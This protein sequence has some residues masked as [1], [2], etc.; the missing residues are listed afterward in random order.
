MPVTPRHTIM[1]SVGTSKCAHMAGEHSHAWME[2]NYI[3]TPF[4]A[5]YQQRPEVAPQKFV[6]VYISD[7]WWEK[8]YQDKSVGCNL[9]RLL[10]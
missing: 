10:A 8:V 3:Q 5:S 7:T 1:L 4:Q 6:L 2:T 9:R